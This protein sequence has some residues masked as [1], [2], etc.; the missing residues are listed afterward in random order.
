MGPVAPCGPVGPVDPVAPCGPVYPVTPVGPV[1]PCGPVGPVVPPVPEFGAT[2]LRTPNPLVERT[3]VLLPP[4]IITFPTAPRFV[5]PFTTRFVVNLPD[6]ITSS[7]Y[8]G[9]CVPIPTFP[10]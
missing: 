5:C 8:T 2:Q 1:A 10:P 9:D 4:V 3:Y 7:V 6:P